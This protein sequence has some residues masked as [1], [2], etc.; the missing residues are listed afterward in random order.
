MTNDTPVHAEDVIPV[1]SRIN[2]GAIAAGAGI[3][4]ALSL[5]LS[6]LGSAIGLSINDRVSDRSLGIGAVVWAILVTA[7]A[8]FVGGFVASQLTT[9]ENKI[10]GALYGVLVWAL[11]FAL[12][13]TVLAN[14]ARTGFS[15]MLGSANSSV[16]SNTGAGNWEDA[17]RKAG[18]PQERID[19]ARTNVNNPDQAKVEENARLAAWYGF[20]GTL[21]SMLA[22]A[23]GGWLGAGP[24][25]KLFAIRVDRTA[26]LDRR[27]TFI[28]T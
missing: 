9:G 13:F 11:T 17:L 24:T 15:A 8:L 7:G 28:R 19:Q 5:L 22:A 14:L 3:A 25:L 27:D 26:A 16:V 1:R 23:I 21:V 12:L 18:V 10:E 20:L 4:L 2:W 6:L